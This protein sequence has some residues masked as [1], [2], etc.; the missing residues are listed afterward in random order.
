MTPRMPLRAARRRPWWL[1]E[2]GFEQLVMLL[3]AVII[4]G[5]GFIAG[6]LADPDEPA[7]LTIEAA[8]AV[9]PPELPGGRLNPGLSDLANVT[10]QRAFDSLSR[11]AA[12]ARLR[13]PVPP[14]RVDFDCAP[15]MEEAP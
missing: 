15:Y 7:V 3:L 2:L 6:H 4:F 13:P 1:G 8:R 14:C 12:A 11:D 5:T 10:L 9:G